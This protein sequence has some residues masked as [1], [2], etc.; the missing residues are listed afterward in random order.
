MNCEIAWHSVCGYV[1]SIENKWSWRTWREQWEWGRAFWK[2][3][4][5]RGRERALTL[6]ERNR[7]L[8]PPSSLSLSLLSLFLSLRTRIWEV[9]ITSE[10]PLLSSS[11]RWTPSHWIRIFWS[12]SLFGS[13]AKTHFAFGPNCKHLGW[14]KNKKAHNSPYLIYT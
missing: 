13:V 6:P 12:E 4:K 1:R 9:T 3:R 10:S 7:F 11:T 5:Q 8:L 2:W 14:I